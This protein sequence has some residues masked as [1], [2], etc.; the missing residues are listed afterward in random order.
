MTTLTALFI[1][2]LAIVNAAGMDHADKRIKALERRLARLEQRTKQPG[3]QA[4]D[5]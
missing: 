2:A 4:S 1:A 3:N 5:T